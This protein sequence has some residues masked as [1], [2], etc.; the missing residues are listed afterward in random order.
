MKITHLDEHTVLKNINDL[1]KLDKLIPDDPWTANNFLKDLDRKWEFSL[2]AI[3]NGIIIGFMICSVK[4]NNL[5][6][7]RIAVSPE[8][9]KKKIGRALIKNLYADCH[10]SGIKRIT[11][12]VKDFNLGA[13]RFYEKHGF[14]KVEL[15]CSRYLCEKELE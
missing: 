10:K 11:L 3:E 8:F 15:E 13:I 14:K 5:H 7:H 12:K 4:E 9:Q 6:V 1:I 2:I